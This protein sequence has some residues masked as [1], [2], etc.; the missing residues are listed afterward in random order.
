MS[1]PFWGDSRLSVRNLLYFE[2]LRR[3]LFE[4][5]RRGAPPEMPF[6][7][8]EKRAEFNKA[9]G[10]RTLRQIREEKPR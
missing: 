9:L 5:I 1:Q 4:S 7:T 3:A 10:K 6:A 2:E 8:S